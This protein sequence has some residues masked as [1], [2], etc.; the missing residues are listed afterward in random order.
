M[1][2][3]RSRKSRREAYPKPAARISR[4]RREGE[5]ARTPRIKKTHFPWERLQGDVVGASSP[6]TSPSRGYHGSKYIVT[7]Y[8]SVYASCTEYMM[9]KDTS[10]EPES[11]FQ[12]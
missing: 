6:L 9:K 4:A 7:D 11:G 10:G 5:V 2:Q 1:E 8:D 12:V 3:S